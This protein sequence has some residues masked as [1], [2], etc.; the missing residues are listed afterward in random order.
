MSTDVVSSRPSTRGR[1]PPARGCRPRR[2]ARR[3]GCNRTR[4]PREGRASGGAGRRV[5]PR[6]TSA[7]RG[8]TRPRVRSRCGGTSVRRASPSYSLLSSD[9]GS[10]YGEGPTSPT[11]PRAAH[12]ESCCACCGGSAWAARRPACAASFPSSNR[13]QP[14]PRSGCKRRSCARHRRCYPTRPTTRC[15][16]SRSSRQSGVEEACLGRE[17]RGGA[18]SQR[19]DSASA[20]SEEPSSR[21]TRSSAGAWSRCRTTTAGDRDDE[22]V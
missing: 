6:A 15:R 9:R 11:Y 5:T 16:S 12:C 10:L 19:L 8:A 18:A 4:R 3:P 22:P 1:R 14:R 13:G 2:S 21:Q 17:L 7:R 20:W